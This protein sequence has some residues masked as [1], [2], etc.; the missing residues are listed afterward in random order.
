[1]A[2][3]KKIRLLAVVLLLISMACATPSI[4]PS[5]ESEINTAVAGT[6]MAGQTQ[7]AVNELLTPPTIQDTPT[8]VPTLTF[9]P[10]PPTATPTPTVVPTLPFTPTAETP[11][12]TVS[13]DTNCRS[14]PGKVYDVVGALLVGEFAE[15]FG[16]DPSNNYWYIL[17]PD[18][19]DPEFCWVWGKYATLTGPAMLAPV[20]TPPPT[21]TATATSLPTPKFTVEYTSMDSCNGFWWVE[22]KLK[23]TGGIPFKSVNISIRDKVTDVVVSDTA[24]GFINLDDCQTKS[25]KEILGI[26]ETFTISTPAFKYNPESHRLFVTITLCSDKGQQGTC[27]TEKIDFEP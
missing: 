25:A 23:N 9:T 3:F 14:G 21:P 7:D 2:S 26:G 16:R 4:F 12:I 5:N 20:F 15:V 27:A 18:S 8:L 6:V 1:M 11:F 13:V 24:D 19:N 10:E 17:N 22:L